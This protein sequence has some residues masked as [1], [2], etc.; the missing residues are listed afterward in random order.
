MA[1]SVFV[2]HSMRPV[3]LPLLRGVCDHLSHHG[4]DYYLA[5]RDWR[6]GESL[7]NRVQNAI[8]RAD[9]VLGFFTMDGE[10]SAYVNQEIGIAATMKK[11]IIPV[12]EKGADLTGFR[13]DLDYLVLDRDAPQD[14]A[15]QLAARLG[16]LNATKD[17]RAAICWAVIATAGLLF[18]GRN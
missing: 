9:C 4:I 6:F 15:A 11:P 16:K 13:S 18:L 7:P 1:F 10:A 12:L 5:E 8:A 2:S 3:D 17:T 14:C